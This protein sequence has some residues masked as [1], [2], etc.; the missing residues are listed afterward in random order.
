MKKKNSTKLIKKRLNRAIGISAALIV[1]CAGLLFGIGS[2]ADEM[3]VVY[4]IPG[5]ILSDSVFT[6]QNTTYMPNAIL[7]TSHRLFDTPYKY[8]M[9][10]VYCAEIDEV[11]LF[12]INANNIV[13]ICISDNNEIVKKATD[14]QEKALNPN[15]EKAKT[16]E[17]VNVGTA[18]GYLNGFNAKYG[19]DNVKYYSGADETTLIYNS[20]NL[21]YV[22]KLSDYKLMYIGV[23][24]KNPSDNALAEAK[25]LL[26]TIY[27]TIRF[28]SESFNEDWTIKENSTYYEELV[29]QGLVT[30]SEDVGT[31]EQIF[32]NIDNDNS[33]NS[34]VG[35]D[36]NVSG[37]AG[38]VKEEE[39]TKKPVNV[40][41][42]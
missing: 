32:E 38:D 16:K 7:P 29:E 27:Y 39:T 6:Q 14:A 25:G 17:V 4:S 36:V 30:E 22:I 15:Y 10:E 33:N 1:I 42:S 9:C 2:V 23:T 35:I 21:Y 24:V 11:K 40:D 41:I 13:S 19:V 8:D 12:E 26:D 18:M 20:Y 37:D 3:P 5:S 31:D 34:N 28:D